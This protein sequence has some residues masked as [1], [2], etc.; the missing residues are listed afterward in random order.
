[1]AA[2]DFV[3]EYRGLQPTAEREVVAARNNSFQKL[4]AEASNMGR[5][6]DIA[7]FAYRL[8]IS[9]ESDATPWFG[10]ILRADDATF[11]IDLDVEE[12]ARIATLVLRQRLYDNLFVTPVIVHAASFAGKRQTVDNHALSLASRQTLANLVRRRGTSLGRPEVT[13]GK[14]AALSE[15]IKKLSDEN[16]DTKDYQVIESAVQDYRSQ[17]K[18]VVTTANKAIETA[19]N[20]SRRLAEEVDLLWWHL[21]GYSFSLDRPLADLPAAL[22]PIAIGMDLGEMINAS[23]GP[24]G[25]YGIIRK[26][27]GK[28][29]DEKFKLGDALKELTAEFGGLIS[30]PVTRYALAP[31]HGAVGEVLLE[32]TPVVGAQFKRHTGLG[33]DVKLTGYEL[34]LQAYHERMLSKLGWI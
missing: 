21:G 5:L 18:Q 8:P 19:W 14:S 16:D 7:Y 3:A 28:A 2:F 31:I 11:S 24:Y 6:L 23:P 33:V 4:Q 26:A 13:S 25:T 22:Q 10:E 12:A 27:L 17:I 34:A 20:E 29:A 1:M 32:G 9:A 15:L 30:K